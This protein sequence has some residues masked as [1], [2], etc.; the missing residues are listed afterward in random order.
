M[1]I[2]NLSKHKNVCK[3]DTELQFG[4]ADSNLQHV[5]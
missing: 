1:L 4:V 2:I 3:V 5:L